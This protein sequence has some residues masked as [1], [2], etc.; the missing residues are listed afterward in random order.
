MDGE[1]GVRKEEGGEGREDGGLRSSEGREPHEPDKAKK[2]SFSRHH[3][4]PALAR[5]TYDQI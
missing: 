4:S 3:F 5:H 1:E 2:P